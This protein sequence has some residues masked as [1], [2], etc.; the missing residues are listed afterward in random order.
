[1]KEGGGDGVGSDAKWG[2]GGKDRLDPGGHHS[3]GS[4]GG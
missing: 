3:F 1:M 4:R 2:G